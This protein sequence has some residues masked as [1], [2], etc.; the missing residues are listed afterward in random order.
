MLICAQGCAELARA[1]AFSVSLKA[2]GV[3]HAGW[4]D[5]GESWGDRGQVHWANSKKDGQG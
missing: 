3:S 4:G 2:L 5:V 1:V